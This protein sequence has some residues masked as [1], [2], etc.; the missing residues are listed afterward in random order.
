MPVSEV[1]GQP[2]W[3][4]RTSRASLALWVG[5][6][7]LVALFVF[8]WQVM[9]KDTIW[10]FVND[11]PRQAADL[12]SRMFPPR[13]SYFE[14]LLWPMWDTLN[15]ATLGTIMGIIIAVPVAFLAARR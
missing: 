9:T 4:H 11:A 8:C 1:N 15:I 13:W 12:G 6:L 3:K 5:W 10:M 2:A 14:R 7:A